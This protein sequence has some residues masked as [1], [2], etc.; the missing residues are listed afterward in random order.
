MK[1]PK[2]RLR[3]DDLSNVVS[4]ANIKSVWR[5]TV[6]EA[7]KRQLIE[8]PIELYDVH[9]NIS[10]VSA[11]I[12]SQVINGDYNPRTP[13]RVLVEKSK[14]LCRQLVV[15]HPYDCLVLQS[16][17][18]NLHLV[19]KPRAPHP[20][21]FYQPDRG[22]NNRKKLDYGGR[23]AWL[24]FQKAILDFSSKRKVLI[25]SDIANFYDTVS[26]SHLRNILSNYM[27]ENKETILDLTL[28][29]LV[30]M[31]WQ[32]DYMPRV[33]IGLPQINLDAPRMLANS[34]LYELDKFVATNKSIDYARY[35]DDI[36]IG[37]DTVRNAKSILR[38][39]DL[40]LQSRQ[41][42][43]NAGKTRIL[44]GDDI[45]KY[46]RTK[47]NYFL[48]VLKERIEGDPTKIIEH[49]KTLGLLFRGW[50]R[51]GVFDGEG[52]GEKILKR[53]VNL[54]IKIDLAIPAQQIGTILQRR[55]NLRE[56]ILRYVSRISGGFRY[57]KAL[58][59][60]ITA[61]DVIDDASALILAYK[62]VELRTPDVLSDRKNICAVAEWMLKR[63]RQETWCY[64]ALW[65]LSKY[66]TQSQIMRAIDQSYP[67]W[68]SDYY[69]GRLVAALE[70]M[71]PAKNKARYHGL[72]RASRNVGAAEVS[73]FYDDIL[74]DPNTTTGIIKFLRANNRNPNKISHP[75]WMVLLHVLDSPAV[76]VS[77]KRYLLNVHSLALS[78]RYYRVRA[79]R[80]LRL[81]MP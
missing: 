38:D 6:R 7:M 81:Q 55:P 59:K 58:L 75:K 67:I 43:L 37:V 68:R 24:D 72:L 20:N 10:N 13:K 57:I 80:H 79:K 74:N 21:A 78:D 18:D 52:N 64:S 11:S 60:F 40:T 30:A 77:T 9:L 51:K 61:P 70:C 12:S 31:L 56:E 66:G 73:A 1:S 17:S 53:I 26:Y 29:V 5:N 16:L 63:E 22:M 32:P 45:N 14:G 44:I 41:L 47:Q 3:R 35:M 76:P 25:V 4:A 71:I 54:A 46:F 19:L 34:F 28:H 8:D 23:K 33:E 50:N 42:R 2:F 49:R 62:L 69:L 36:D 39:I 65:L 48:D 27:P 15:P